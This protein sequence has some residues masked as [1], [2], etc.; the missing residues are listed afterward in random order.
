MAGKDWEYT[1]WEGGYSGAGKSAVWS[2]NNI[3]GGIF[4][5]KVF[6]DGY[7]KRFG[8]WNKVFIK[9]EEEE[10]IPI[11]ERT[12]EGSIFI[13]G[14][15]NETVTNSYSYGGQ[16]YSWSYKVKNL[17]IQSGDIEYN[18]LTKRFKSKWYQ[19]KTWILSDSI[20]SKRISTDDKEVGHVLAD[21]QAFYNINAQGGFGVNLA[22]RPEDVAYYPYYEKNCLGVW[23]RGF[24]FIKRYEYQSI[25]KNSLDQES[26]FARDTSYYSSIFQ[27]LYEI[28]RQNLT[29]LSASLSMEDCGCG[30]FHASGEEAANLKAELIKKN[31][32]AYNFTLH[33]IDQNLLNKNIT[34]QKSKFYINLEEFRAHPDNIAEG[35]KMYKGSEEEKT[36]DMFSVEF[37]DCYYKDKSTLIEG[38]DI[39]KLEYDWRIYYDLLTP[40]TPCDIKTIVKSAK[41]MLVEDEYYDG[42]T[43]GYL[44]GYEEDI[45]PI[46][47]RDYVKK[48]NYGYNSY[49]N[50]SQY[51]PSHRSL[52]HLTFSKVNEIK[53]SQQNTFALFNKVEYVTQYYDPNTFS[54][55][56]A[57]GGKTVTAPLTRQLL[58]PNSG[59]GFTLTWLFDNSTH[60]VAG[61]IVGFIPCN[62]G[63]LCAMKDAGPC[64]VG[65]YKAGASASSYYLEDSGNHGSGYNNQSFGKA[66]VQDGNELG[67]S[68]TK[69]YTPSEDLLANIAEELA[70]E[71]KETI[72]TAFN[73]FQ[74]NNYYYSD[75]YSK[76]YQYIPQ[77]FFSNRKYIRKETSNEEQITYEIEGS[78]EE[79][80]TFR[81]TTK[82]T[83]TRDYSGD[84][85]VKEY[86]TIIG[87]PVY[88]KELITTEKTFE[89]EDFE[90]GEIIETDY[91][92][93]VT[94][95]SYIEKEATNINQFD[96]IGNNSVDSDVTAREITDYIR[97][98]GRFHVPED[99]P[100]IND[101]F[102]NYFFI[103]FLNPSALDEL[104]YIPEKY[105]YKY[106]EISTEDEEYPDPFTSTTSSLASSS[107]G[108]GG[109]GNGNTFT[110]TYN[111]YGRL[112]PCSYDISFYC[113]SPMKFEY[114][115]EGN[116]TSS[117]Y[118]RPYQ[119]L[120]CKW[121]RT[122]P[123]IGHVNNS[124]G[125]NTS[126]NSD[127]TITSSTSGYNDTADAYSENDEFND[128]ITG[129]KTEKNISRVVSTTLP[130]YYSIDFYNNSFKNSPF[131]YSA[132]RFVECTK[133]S[134]DVYIRI[135]K[136]IIEGSATFSSFLC[137]PWDESIATHYGCCN[138]EN[139]NKYFFFNNK[140][141]KS[142]KSYEAT[143]NY[144][145]LHNRFYYD[146]TP[147]INFL[148]EGVYPSGKENCF[149]MM[150]VWMTDIEEGFSGIELQINDFTNL[151]EGKCTTGFNVPCDTAMVSTVSLENMSTSEKLNI[152]SKDEE[153]TRY[154]TNK[155]IFPIL[156]SFWHSE[157]FDKEA[158]FAIETQCMIEGPEYFFS[159]SAEELPPGF[160]ADY[161]GYLSR[162][163]MLTTIKNGEYKN[164]Y[165][166]EDTGFF[167]Y[168]KEQNKKRDKINARRAYDDAPEDMREEQGY[169]WSFEE[170]F[171]PYEMSSPYTFETQLAAKMSFTANLDGDIGVLILLA[172]DIDKWPAD[173][174]NT[175]NENFYEHPEIVES[176]KYKLKTAWLT[177]DFNKEEVINKFKDFQ[178]S[179]VFC[180]LIKNSKK[181]TDKK[182]KDA[183]REYAYDDDK[184]KLLYQGITVPKKYNLVDTKDNEWLP[185]YEF[186]EKER[187]KLLIDHGVIR[188]VRQRLFTWREP[189]IDT[190]TGKQIKRNDKPVFIEHRDAIIE[191]AVNYDA[192]NQSG[193]VDLFYT[194][195]KT[196]L[197]RV[198]KSDSKTD[199]EKSDDGEEIYEVCV[200][201]VEIESL[202]I[203]KTMCWQEE[204][205]YVGNTY[206]YSLHI[207]NLTKVGI[208][209]TLKI[210]EKAEDVP[211][212]EQKVVMEV[213]TIPVLTS[214]NE[215]FYCVSKDCKNWEITGK[216]G[217]GFLS[218]QA[219]NVELTEKDKE[220]PVE[221]E[222]KK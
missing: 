4:R 170:A 115:D 207:Y 116:V 196:V 80:Y 89:Y 6:K 121:D 136:P 184:P 127:G 43:F 95:G 169:Y 161:E 77:T 63:Q 56:G 215:T 59:A 165:I 220:N 107:G 120:N 54:T 141:N 167:E 202:V 204:S 146:K 88:I 219:S 76:R 187:E 23:P 216:V 118:V 37:A 26:A 172:Y 124:G 22:T 173:S 40:F 48:N 221:D 33:S 87:E 197:L 119:G 180:P 110:T 153:D 24:P 175:P 143:T 125:W 1:Q 28:P 36:Y 42:I 11:R 109:G 96:G 92:Y 13:S 159:S 74:T 210:K 9:E 99:F 3:E 140:I 188:V 163:L 34:N 129:E 101:L 82:T 69:T 156:K 66:G 123:S 149:T 94:D 209:D 72:S 21:V 16:T 53:Q 90:T 98:K 200:G 148:T 179:E 83:D 5:R 182:L 68:E 41:V 17:L 61:V 57:C 8:E 155:G 174:K 19:A 208:F 46:Y 20:V 198:S 102:N 135:D 205:G 138:T 52:R 160:E 122:L 212:E 178:M 164:K 39:T 218:H 86:G 142:K 73:P 194:G 176:E 150:N 211:P 45:T 126:I 62:D 100:P 130:D 105:E 192:D 189:K 206:N 12:P 79:G 60:G 117:Y 151:F 195:E 168:F 154:V 111:S 35:I 137:H 70:D 222:T 58:N 185:Q 31:V 14:W 65:H 190:K 147:Y 47:L 183:G 85:E 2:N 97:T 18:S 67:E 32:S 10:E 166:G 214:N 29:D 84:A 139:K 7:A 217:N 64:G 108:G 134:L 144:Q 213:L 55:S 44:K 128:Y 132:S 93:A 25:T 49:F 191:C 30:K 114:D 27:E 133:K 106:H 162:G 81:V 71:N 145:N 38:S 199:T 177:V 112:D 201:D 171:G 50:L 152:F 51:Y 15:G 78:E 193:T 157:K 75:Y 91:T 203:P 104:S 158:F 103:D 181:W 113:N 131:F 186:D